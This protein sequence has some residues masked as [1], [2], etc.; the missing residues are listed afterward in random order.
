MKS[1]F[2]EKINKIDRTL[3]KVNKGKEERAYIVKLG[4][5]KRIFSVDPEEVQRLLRID[6]KYVLLLI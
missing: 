4:R 3:A 1:C 5:R 6:Y 2:F